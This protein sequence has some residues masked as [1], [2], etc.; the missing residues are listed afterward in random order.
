MEVQKYLN[1]IDREVKK[2]N[3]LPIKIIYKKHSKNNNK[4][5][6]LSDKND[7]INNIDFDKINIELSDI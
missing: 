3:I 1:L 6:K 4:D 5:I 7:E 2:I